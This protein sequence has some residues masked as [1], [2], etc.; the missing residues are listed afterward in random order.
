M[1]IGDTT[2]LMAKDIA[3]EMV[4]HTLKAMT[5]EDRRKV[6]KQ[7]PVLLRILMNTHNLRI[8]YKELFLDEDL[9]TAVKRG[10]EMLKHI[11]QT[12]KWMNKLHGD[13]WEKVHEEYEQ[14]NRALINYLDGHMPK[15]TAK[16]I[17]ERSHK[18]VAWI[19]A[20]GQA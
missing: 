10:R 8:Y 1:I 2:T 7:H 12:G 11:E 20:G 16:R 5:L 6:I 14:Q 3:G 17:I 18:R 13:D 4:Y 9:L 15:R 19:V